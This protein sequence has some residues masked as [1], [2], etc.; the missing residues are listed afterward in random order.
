VAAAAARC[1]EEA[2]GLS[3]VLGYRPR[4]GRQTRKA[5]AA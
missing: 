5:G 4:A 3:A 2:A 1:A